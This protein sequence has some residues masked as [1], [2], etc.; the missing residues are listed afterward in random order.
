MKFDFNNIFN[1]NVNKKKG[2]LELGNIYSNVQ[3]EYDQYQG[4]IEN[5]NNNQ[6]TTTTDYDPSKNGGYP[7][8]KV[9]PMGVNFNKP[10]SY[11]EY[12]TKDLTGFQKISK[13]F[14]GQYPSQE[15]KMAVY[16]MLSNLN[17]AELNAYTLDPQGFTKKY[18]ERFNTEAKDR[19]IVE[20]N[21]VKNY[22]MNDGS[23]RPVSKD[24]QPDADFF[25]VDGRLY[26]RTKI[27]NNSPTGYALASP[28]DKPDY[29]N[30]EDWQITQL[31]LYDKQEQELLQLPEDSD[32]RI[33][34]LREI[35]NGRRIIL[36]DDAKVKEEYNVSNS[37]ATEPFLQPVDKNW[38]QGDRDKWNEVASK[39]ALS[40]SNAM[41][42]K[43]QFNPTFLESSGKAGYLF[44]SF[45]EKTSPSYSIERRNEIFE[46]TFG[47]TYM[48]ALTGQPMTKGEM[49][50]EQ[51]L[52]YANSLQAQNSIIRDQT[53]AVMNI[54]ETTRILKSMPDTGLASPDAGGISGIPTILLGGDSPYQFAVKQ[55]DVMMDLGRTH[56]R[57]NIILQN[58]LSQPDISI[59]SLTLNGKTISLDEWH[60]LD[61]KEKIKDWKPKY[62]NPEEVGEFRE[63]PYKWSGGLWKDGSEMTLDS[64][65]Q[66]KAVKTNGMITYPS[67]LQKGFVPEEIN[68]KVDE[69]MENNDGSYDMYM[70]SLTKTKEN[71]NGLT[72]QEYIASNKTDLQKRN[73]IFY[74]IAYPIT[75]TKYGMQPDNLPYNGSGLSNVMNRYQIEN[76]KK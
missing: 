69:I 20:V 8:H 35:E 71:P 61:R 43:N 44:N 50:D 57:T 72:L 58:R 10:E 60:Q 46:D 76:T 9:A 45:L 51:S 16:D 33:V 17:E 25:N 40:M 64:I 36:G 39:S 55:D 11:P 52:F 66:S 67:H 70:R 41:Q 1:N 30:L 18:H 65:W 14:G 48:N 21:G 73:V 12:V 54:N 29:A 26:D 3:N 31:N 47:K 19:R 34:G 6:P 68:R 5:N 56:L 42:V 74:G 75:L 63:T 62:V 24:E 2:I 32:E 23:L 28:D 13:L 15:H 49:Y 7:I 59:E 4:L 37:S 38:S 22:I 27:D 53:G